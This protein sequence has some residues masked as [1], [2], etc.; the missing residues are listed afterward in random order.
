MLEKRNKMGR[1]ERKTK[2]NKHLI[3]LGII[4]L[5][6]VIIWGFYMIA[7]IP[8]REAR[9]EA[10]QMAEKYAKVENIDNFYIY[11]RNQ[12]YYTIEGE[13]NNHQEVFVVIPK[14][15][16]RVD[17]Y[18]KDKGIS[19]KKARQIVQ[20]KYNPQKIKQVVFGMKSGKTPIWEV[21]YENQQGNLCYAEVAFK[22][23]N[24]LQNI[25]NL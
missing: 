22:N 6:L 18:E 14:K 12:T 17:I 13:N 9:N 15:G 4:V 3:I 19:L 11:N 8:Y 23:G 16:N 21:A 1:V 2:R 5:I 24:V 20:N 10:F 25:T 7:R